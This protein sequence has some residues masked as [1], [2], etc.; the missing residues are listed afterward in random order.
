M[1]ILNEKECEIMTSLSKK[2]HFF[3]NPYHYTVKIKF[4]FAPNLV[5]A[6]NISTALTTI[7]V[8]FDLIYVEK[9]TTNTGGNA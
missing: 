7:Y 5:A 2:N 8:L 4:N 9:T 1:T 6:Y 3:T